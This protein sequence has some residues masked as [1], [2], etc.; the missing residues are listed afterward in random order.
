MFTQA[1]SM[2]SAGRTASRVAAVRPNTY[3]PC[4]PSALAGTP[5]PSHQWLNGGFGISRQDEKVL[6]EVA[7]T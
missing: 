3:A 1:T 4:A 5:K 7:L 6:P 2:L